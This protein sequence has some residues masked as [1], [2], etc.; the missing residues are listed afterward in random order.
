MLKVKHLTKKYG[1]QIILND[2]SFSLSPSQWL[3]LTGESGCGKS[4]LLKAIVNEIDY[5][6]KIDNKFTFTSMSHQIDDLLNECTVYENC[7]LYKA[8]QVTEQTF[9][10]LLQ[11]FDLTDCLHQRADSLSGGQKQRVSILRALLQMPDLLL[12]DEPT[13]QL[14]DELA[15]K[16]M[17]VLKEYQ[18]MG[19]TIIMVTHD[20]SLLPYASDTMVLA[21]GKLEVQ[22]SSLIKHIHTKSCNRH[23]KMG[24][25]LKRDFIFQKKYYMQIIL[26]ISLCLPLFLLGL[27]IGKHY[28]DDLT[29]YLKNTDE[30][31]RLHVNLM[32]EMTVEEFENLLSDVDVYSIAINYDLFRLNGEKYINDLPINANF[33][34]PTNQKLEN[35][36]NLAL[37]KPLADELDLKVGDQVTLKTEIISGYTTKKGYRLQGDYIWHTPLYEYVEETFILDEIITEKENIIYLSPRAINQYQLYSQLKPDLKTEHFTVNLTNENSIE[38]AKNLLKPL[39]NPSLGIIDLESDISNTQAGLIGQFEPFR[40]MSGLLIIVLAAAIIIIFHS[41]FD[42]SNSQTH[43]LKQLNVPIK[44]IYLYHTYRICIIGLISLITTMSIYIGSALLI[45]LW[46]NPLDYTMLA[47]ALIPLLSDYSFVMIDIEAWTM[48]LQVSGLVSLVY[49]GIHSLNIWSI[50][51]I[52]KNKY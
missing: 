45:N 31:K 27:N 50:N 14:N 16:V 2:I 25:L 1:N 22:K 49:L 51:K 15:Y 26:A 30:A 11:A 40:M 32:Q 19:T 44:S 20:L 24:L 46:F 33:A 4:T 17:D 52:F 18:E 41:S 3:M 7:M 10:H 8:D 36:T 29:T 35:Q 42:I 13:S 39:V 23:F 38:K 48:F 47:P 12:L 28:Q 21:H 6:G 37:S 34:K 5:D 43:I 9:K